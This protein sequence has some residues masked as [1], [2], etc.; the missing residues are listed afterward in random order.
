MVGLVIQLSGFSV[1]QSL[2][3]VEVCDRRKSEA[4]EQATI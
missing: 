3:R 4:F 2:R 1:E